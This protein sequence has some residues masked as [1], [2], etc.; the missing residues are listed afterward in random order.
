MLSPQDRSAIEGLF[1]RLAEIEQRTPPRDAEA[2]A[3]IRQRVGEQPGAPYY[4]AQ[5]ILVQEA[6]L[7]EARERIAELERQAER[8]ESG[9]GG[10]FGGFFGDDRDRNRRPERDTRD[11]P[12]RTRGPWDRQDD[13]QRGGGG[14]LAGA[15]QT[16]LGVTGGILLGQ[17]IG[18]I[19]SAGSAQAAEAPPSEPDA[20]QGDAGDA[21]GGFDDFGGFDMGGDF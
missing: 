19:F 9:A 21:G 2:E 15:A 16:A 11:L 3:L 7:A 8:R 13:Y 1:D 4:M 20:D 17:A 6:A 18:S 14:F 10:L 12:Q 5:T